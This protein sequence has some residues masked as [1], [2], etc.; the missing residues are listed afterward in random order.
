[1][2][3]REILKMGNPILRELSTPL[4]DK[5]ILSSE[6]QLLINDL[7][8]TMIHANGL[9]LAAPQIGILKQI[10]V[11][12]LS[13][14]NI[15]YQIQDD[16]KTYIIINP[17]IDILDNVT[18]GYWEG[19][20]SVPGLRGFVERPS[21]IKIEYKD[22]FAQNQSL[23]LEGFIATV[24]QHEIDHLFGKLYLDQMKDMTKLSFNEEFEK[25]W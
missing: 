12:K 16:S 22:E 17:K 20:L 25:Y 18:Q 13:K 21:K 15:R 23:N 1:M 7:M 6:T 8:D 2:P 4:S 3:V 5:E 14:D 11:I 9:G 10:A 19:C 24:F